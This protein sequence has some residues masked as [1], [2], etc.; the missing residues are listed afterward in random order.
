MRIPSLP[1]QIRVCPFTRLDQFHFRSWVACVFLNIRPSY[2]PFLMVV[3]FLNFVGTQPYGQSFDSFRSSPRSEPPHKNFLFPPIQLRF[4]FPAP[5]SLFPSSYELLIWGLFCVVVK[6]VQDFT[7]SCILQ[8]PTFCKL[9]F[10]TTRHFF[11]ILPRSLPAFFL[12]PSNLA[13]YF[14]HE[15]A[16]LFTPHEGSLSFCVLASLLSF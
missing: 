2:P 7:F 8:S 13:S 10:S 6:T 1:H 16:R 3:G 11:R 14:P 5:S 9:S 4:C 12:P 15:A